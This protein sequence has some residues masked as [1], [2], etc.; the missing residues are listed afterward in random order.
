MTKGGNRDKDECEQFTTPPHT[1]PQTHKAYYYAYVMYLICK[2]VF[3][4]YRSCTFIYPTIKYGFLKK[5]H[6]CLHLGMVKLKSQS[7]THTHT[8]F[9]IMCVMYR[10]EAKNMDG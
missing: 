1:L 5:E 6:V 10:V 3:V 4:F 9:Y 8:G 2:I 7:R